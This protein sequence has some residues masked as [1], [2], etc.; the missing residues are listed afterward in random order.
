MLSERLLPAEAVVEERLLREVCSFGPGGGEVAAG[1]RR[2]GD[3]KVCWWR[4]RQRCNLLPYVGMRGVTAPRGCGARAE[5]PAPRVR[6][7]VGRN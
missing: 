7:R 6:L 2:R 3:P 5:W 4:K 1:F